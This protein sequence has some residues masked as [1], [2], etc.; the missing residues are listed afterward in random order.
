MVAWELAREFGVTVE[1]LV[2]TFAAV[3]IEGLVEVVPSVLPLP[4]PCLIFLM[5]SLRH[6]LRIESHID[7]LCYFYCLIFNKN[8]REWAFLFNGER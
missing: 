7:F 5:R 3:L 2:A 1:G 4:V 8:C 6:A